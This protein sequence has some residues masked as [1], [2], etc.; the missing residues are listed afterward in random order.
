MS[1]GRVILHVEGKLREIPYRKHTYNTPRKKTKNNT[2]GGAKIIENETR[3]DRSKDYVE[4]IGVL[5]NVEGKL[6]HNRGGILIT[7]KGKQNEK[8]TC[9]EGKKVIYKEN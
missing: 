5:L 2:C 7:H 3:I 4:R 9:G 1:R 6:K 8:N